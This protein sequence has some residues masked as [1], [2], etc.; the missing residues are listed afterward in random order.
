VGPSGA[1]KTTLVNAIGGLI[2][3]D[4]GELKLFGESTLDWSRGQ[5]RTAR[6]S[7][8]ILFQDPIAMLNPGLTIGAL[9]YESC[10]IHR[11]GEDAHALTNQILEQVELAGRIHAFPRELSGGEQRRAGLA[12]VLLA[13]P[14]LLIVDEPTAGLDPSLKAE[15][16]EMFFRHIDSNTAVLLISH[17]LPVVAWACQ[18]I[19]VMD[20]GR[21]VD[22]LASGDAGMNTH[23]A[24]AE[25][26]SGRLSKLRHSKH[27]QGPS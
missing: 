25:A 16:V 10:A 23:V 2:R 15:L 27:L 3:P 12:R 8:Q 24:T 1:G 5:W 14:R 13:R 26:L 18:R 19:L 22:Q 20:E 11:T 4:A 6:R 9:L 21:I 17:D 7:L